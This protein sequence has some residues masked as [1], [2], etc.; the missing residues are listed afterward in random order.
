MK[1]SHINITMPKGNEDMARAFY[2]NFLGL[3]EI[4][5][6]PP[7]RARGGVWFDAGGIDLHVSATDEIPQA[8]AQ[9]HFGLEC[10]DME[11]L[12]EKLTKAAIT[13][14]P[15]RPAPW[16]RFFIRDPFGNRIEIH[17]PGAMRG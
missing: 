14:D 15:G 11:R 13:I 16:K 8:D 7:L 10:A 6:P 1:L 4:P 2:G 12:R 5:K 9:R 17:E 3:K